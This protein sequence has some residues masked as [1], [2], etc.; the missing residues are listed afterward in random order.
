MYCLIVGLLSQ[1]VD[2]LCKFDLSAPATARPTGETN[3]AIGGY[4]TLITIAMGLRLFDGGKELGGI[5]KHTF[6]TFSFACEN[7]ISLS[8]SG[9]KESM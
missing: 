9:S 7:I 2:I 4:M 3:I 6:N 8:N 1:T 5:R